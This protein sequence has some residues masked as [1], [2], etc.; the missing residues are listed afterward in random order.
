ML[1]TYH[2]TQIG[3]TSRFVMQRSFAIILIKLYQLRCPLPQVVVLLLLLLSVKMLECVPLQISHVNTKLPARTVLW[4]SISNG[5]VK[6]SVCQDWGAQIHHYTGWKTVN[7]GQLMLIYYTVSKR[8]PLINKW[9]LARL[10]INT[11]NASV[12]PI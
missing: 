12:A 7:L 6:D 2:Q 3:Y 1:W 5:F 8:N 10:S 4:A 9:S 11:L